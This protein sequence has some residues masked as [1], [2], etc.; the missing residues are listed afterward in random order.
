MERLIASSQEPITLPLLVTTIAIALQIGAD[1]VTATRTGQTANPFSQKVL[2]VNNNCLKAALINTAC[3]FI[4]GLPIMSAISRG[5]PS[6]LPKTIASYTIGI[7]AFTLI[8]DGLINLGLADRTTQLIDKTTSMARTK[9]E[10]VL[11]QGIDI[12]LQYQEFLATTAIQPRPL[13]Y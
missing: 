8:V 12:S 7:L 13:P 3:G 1:T 6:E 2:D 9:L 5:N 11:N 10:Q 4:S